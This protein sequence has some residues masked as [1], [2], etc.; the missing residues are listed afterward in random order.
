MRRN[1][2]CAGTSILALAAIASAA[3]AQTVG[4]DGAAANPPPSPGQDVS[5]DDRASTEVEVSDIVVTARRREERLVDVPVAITAL[6]QGQLEKQGLQNGGDLERAVPA[7]STVAVNSRTSL[8]FAIRGQSQ[9]FGSSATPVIVYFAEVPLSA[10]NATVPFFD[11]QSVQV[12]AG[13]Q[14]TLFGR[15]ATGGAVLFEPQRPTG[16]LGSYGSASFGNLNYVEL[17]GALNLPVIP[18]TLAIRVAGNFL[19]RDGFT[20]DLTFGQVVD[21]RREENYRVSALLTPTSNIENLFVFDYR[22]YNALPSSFLLYEFSVQHPAVVA[23]IARAKE[24][25]PR[26]I[27]N[28]PG[29]G[30]VFER[31]KTWGISNRT[32]IDLGPVTIKNIFGY[33]SG[34]SRANIEGDGALIRFAAFDTVGPLVVP[35]FDDPSF[36]DGSKTL[37]EELQFQ[38]KLWDDRIDWIVGGFYSHTRAE[39][40]SNYYVTSYQMIE[41]PVGPGTTMTVP[42]ELA[43]N[44]GLGVKSRSTSKAVFGQVTLRPLEGLSVT[45]GIRYSKDESSS[46]NTTTNYLVYPQFGLFPCGI[47]IPGHDPNSLVGCVR[48][49]GSA[50]NSTSYNL[51][52]DYQFSRNWLVYVAH[53]RGSNPGGVNALALP[54][55]YAKFQSFS[56]ETI[57]D[58]ELGLKGDWRAGDARGF[59]GLAAY[60]SWYKNRQRSFAIS[61]AS[62]NINAADS[63]ISGLEAQANLQWGGLGLNGS[64][65]YTDA[66]FDRY[67]NLDGVDLS[68]NAYAYAPKHKITLSAEYKFDFGKIGSL[69]PSVNYTWSDK[70]FYTDESNLYP[71]GFVPSYGLLNGRITLVPAG[72]SGLEVALFARN[73]TDK[74]YI[75]TGDRSLG[76]GRVLYGEPR[77][78]GIQLRMKTG[79]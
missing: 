49:Q 74:T 12:L 45:G 36:P 6:S 73:L 39:S 53:R 56:A 59:I 52:V 72:R 50:F 21:N 8:S 20:R 29:Q 42:F 57:D 71:N 70:F 7:L 38:G 28:S 65:T 77:T 3:N 37:S 44:A 10:D 15:S 62:V 1:L 4:V 61:G 55:Q 54:A 32:T 79:S 34:W 58:L 40:I 51:S 76:I 5:Q 69:T 9:G 22:H 17:E 63:V 47:N 43:V 26:T 25:G 27:E 48:S 60:R 2:F 64:Y 18:D 14:G 33:R 68:G 66:T 16:T 30:Q 13:P 11:L 78:W 41:V 19:R 24:L 23:A 46:V 75:Q 35:G 67:Q 31:R